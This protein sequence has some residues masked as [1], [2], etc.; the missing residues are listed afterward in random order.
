MSR[1][2]VRFLLNGQCIATKPLNSQDKLKTVREKIKEKMS[3]SQYFLTRDGDI[4][5]VN[6]EED[7]IVEDVID[8]K[9]IINIKRTEDKK[10]IRI[11]INDKV[12]TTIEIDNKTPLSDV[13]KIVQ[14][15]PESAYFYTPDDDRVERDNEEEYIVEDIINNEEINLKEEKEKSTP[16][17][18]DITIG[19]CLNGKPLIKKQFNKNISLSDVRKE[20]ENVKQI[21]KDFVFEDLEGFKIPSDDEQTLKLT[22][23]LHDNKINITTELDETSPN[24]EE[25]NLKEEKENIPEVESNVPI[26]GSIRLESHE[27]GKLK[28]YLYPNQ[29]FNQIDESDAIAILVVGQTG[30]GKTTLLNSFVN[31]IYG[32]KITDDFRYIIINEDNLKQYGDKSV[33]Q[34]SQVSIYNIKRTKRTPPIKII[35]TPG[36]GDTRGIEWDQ[37]ITKQIKEAFENK[38]SDL[39]AI[40]F[41]AQSSNVKLTVS[42]KYIFGNIINLFGKDVKK[43]FVAML[44]FCDGEKPQVI[45]ALQS[46]DC[47]FSTIIPEIDEPWYLKFNNSAIYSDNT[48]DEFTQMFWKLGMKNFDDFITKLVK[49]P[50]I[51]LEQSREVLKRRE[52]IK[53]QLDAIKISLNIGFSKMNEINQICKQLYLNREKVKNNENFTITTTETVKKRV[54]LKKGEVVIKCYQ[55]NNICHD[56]CHCPHGIKDGEEVVYC[57]IDQTEDKNCVVCGHYYTHHKYSTYRYVYET[58]KKQETAKDILDRYNAGK[59]GVAD[60]ES[61]LKKLEEEYYNIQMDCRDKQQ[62]LV[63]CVNKLSEIAL[64]GKVTSSSEYL[65]MMIQ[66]ENDEKKPGYKERIEGYKQLKQA[67]EMIEDIMKN[68]TTKKS[69]EEIK[70]EVKR[71]MKELKEGEKTTTDKL[72]EKLRKEFSK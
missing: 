9:R 61:I 10:G 50:R 40:C 38:V 53:A 36:F 69:K 13:R 19:I 32:I 15:I 54:D 5:D 43:N 24:N 47:I 63:E 70:A 46:K 11:K 29:E 72:F 35:D 59:K 31:A 8:E 30:S 52:Q 49:L 1:V 44:T 41:V 64:N 26:E 7:F 51:S 55:C 16:E 17:I 60:A 25:I 39:N 21:P 12:I 22:S 45:N 48:E 14:N 37:K 56:P 65:D 66:T 67:N 2:I 33:S 57:Y 23:I 28:I 71:R 4:I 34:T 68:S 62:E 42:Q 20:I 3:D 58:V 18:N 6:D 27:N